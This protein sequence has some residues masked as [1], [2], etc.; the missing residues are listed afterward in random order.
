[1]SETL[2]VLLEVMA[3][4]TRQDMKWGTQNWT[5]GGSAIFTR[6]AMNAREACNIAAQEGTLSW[7]HIMREEF[8]ELFA[9]DDSEPEKQ[10]AEAVQVAAVA[11][12][13]V[14]CIDRKARLVPTSVIEFEKDG[15]VRRW[16]GCVEDAPEAED[17]RRDRA[18]EAQ[19]ALG[20]E[21]SPA[22]QAPDDPGPVRPAA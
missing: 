2:N 3:E 1:M 20:Q 18:R 16:R 12:A 17:A 10:R 21:A 11:V 8:W 13:M 5:V 9:E 6:T 14:E 15:V 22:D 7:R 19:S 4:R